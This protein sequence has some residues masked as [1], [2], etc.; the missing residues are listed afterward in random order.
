MRP[1]PSLGHRGRPPTTRQ[2]PAGDETGRAHAYGRTLGSGVTSRARRPSQPR[3]ATWYINAFDQDYAFV[4]KILSFEAML[5]GLSLL[6][7]CEQREAP[8]LSLLDNNRHRLLPDE[9]AST[10]LAA[11][12]H[13][14]KLFDARL[15]GFRPLGGLD[16]RQDGIAVGL[17]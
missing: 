14:Y 2:G 9:G 8:C 15:P 5:Q 17:G 13:G 1:V 11:G 6:Q 7:E 4:T 12:E 16:T 3:P 10:G